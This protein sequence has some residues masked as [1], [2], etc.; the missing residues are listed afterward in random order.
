M[1]GI[2]GIDTVVAQYQVWLDGELFPFPKMKV[3]ILF[4][5]DCGYAAHP[6]LHRKDPS[7]GSIEYLCGLGESSEVAL[8]NLLTRFIAEA[9]EH[10]LSKKLGE[11]DFEWSAHEDF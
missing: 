6:N 1:N 7:T 2:A 10:S 3:K 11:A 5:P 4:R 9:R 8:N